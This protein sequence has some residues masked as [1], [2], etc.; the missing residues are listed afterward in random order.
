MDY[1]NDIWRQ[2][3]ATVP[4]AKQDFSRKKKISYIPEILSKEA[5]I[6]VRV[7]PTNN[8]KSIQIKLRGSICSLLKLKGKSI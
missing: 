1:M 3:Q 6:C 2:I 4:S 5:G 8:K 7:I